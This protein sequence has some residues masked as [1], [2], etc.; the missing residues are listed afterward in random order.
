MKV[1][2]VEVSA[3]R[4]FNHPYESYSNYRPSVTLTATLDDSE[5]VAEATRKL[6]AQAEA[7]AE[8]QKQQQLKACTEEFNKKYHE[9]GQEVE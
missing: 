2:Q 1:T 4:T 3:G 9:Q 5:D 6:Q 7:L 8:E